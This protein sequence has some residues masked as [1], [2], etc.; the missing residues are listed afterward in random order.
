MVKALSADLDAACRALQ[1]GQIVAIPTETFYGLA[2][3]PRN[4]AAIASLSRLKKR[5]SAQAMPL[6]ASSHAAIEAVFGALPLGFADLAKHFWPGPLTMALRP[7]KQ[8]AW[9]GLMA[10]DGTLGVRI[11]PHPIA[12][13]LA[14]AC[15]GM[16]TATSANMRGEP[17]VKSTEALT[18]KL[19]AQ[20]GFVLD[21]GVC[22]GG[23]PSTV[24]AGDGQDPKKIHILRPGCLSKADLEQIWLPAVGKGGQCCE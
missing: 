8:D 11:S 12:C 15:G 6:I 24:I 5:A 13:A 16:L 2:V 20:L 10:Q 7:I 23:A 19:K 17:A 3:D 18:P 1:A 22:P 4:A 9:H 21:A 14:D